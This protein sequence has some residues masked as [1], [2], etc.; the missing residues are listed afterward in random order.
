MVPQL[1]ISQLKKIPV[2]FVGLQLLP[3]WENRGRNL[4]W[5]MDYLWSS[6]QV[7]KTYK[8]LLQTQVSCNTCAIDFMRVQSLPATETNTGNVFRNWLFRGQV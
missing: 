1:V 2:D 8:D 3:A 5:Q 7:Y 6:G 4:I